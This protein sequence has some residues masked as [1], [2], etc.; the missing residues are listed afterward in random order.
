LFSIRNSAGAHADTLAHERLEWLY[1]ATGGPQL[2]L[3]LRRRPKFDEIFL[4]AIVQLDTGH[5]LRVAAI[6]RLRKAKNRRQ[7]PHRLA[8]FRS[9]RGERL[10]R[11]FRRRFA[12]VARTER[13]HVDFFRLEPP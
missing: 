5:D 13:D 9:Q 2:Q 12:V 7:R 1:L 3:R 10:V 4:A 8:R 11:S 6:E